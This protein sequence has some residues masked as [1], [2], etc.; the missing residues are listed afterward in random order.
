MLKR[1]LFVFLMVIALSVATV[2]AVNAGGDKVRGEN[3]EGDVVQ[4]CL[5]FGECPYGDY[6]PTP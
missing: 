4:N 3:G 2:S 5:N 6:T 1:I